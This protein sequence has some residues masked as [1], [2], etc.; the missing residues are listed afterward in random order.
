MSL[1]CADRFDQFNSSLLPTLPQHTF[2][3]TKAQLQQLNFQV[4]M[5]LLHLT[6]LK[7]MGS[8]KDP[9][10]ALSG[11]IPVKNEDQLLQFA[12][13]SGKRAIS[14]SIYLN[15]MLV[16]FWF[17]RF[18][19]AGELALKYDSSRMF[20]VA[21]A[22]HVYYRTL[23]ALHLARRNPDEAKW[24]AVAEKGLASVQMWAQHSSWNFEH[25][26]LIIEAEWHFTKGE[27]LAAEPK[28]KAAIESARSHRFVHEEGLANELLFF[29]YD[30]N[31]NAGDSKK[32]HKEARSC[33][34]RWGA[35]ALVNRIDSTYEDSM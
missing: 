23:I 11:A 32:H 26:L 1:C 7:L 10:D 24:M 20:G 12:L 13:Q 21:D 34:E 2:R 33:Y 5:A 19:E 27:N 6:V 31:G 18:E 28:Y 3:L 29:F 15:K 9:F 35:T 30:S 4:A 8:D 22:L 14:Q 25:R 17:K 16:A